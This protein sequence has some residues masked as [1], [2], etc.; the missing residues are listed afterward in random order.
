MQS[1]QRN[2]SHQKN[3]SYLNVKGH[4]N[5]THKIFYPNYNFLQD[6]MLQTPG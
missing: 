3:I 1:P 4:L 6:G 2:H 5:P